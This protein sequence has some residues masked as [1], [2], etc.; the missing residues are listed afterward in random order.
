[1]HLANRSERAYP[2]VAVA[3]WRQRFMTARTFRLAGASASVASLLVATAARAQDT[4][5]L[6]QTLLPDESGIAFVLI[7]RTRLLV[8]RVKKE[9][10]TAHVVEVT[11]AAEPP[12]TFSLRCVDQAAARQVVD[13][14][15]AGGPAMLD[16][17]G[18]CRL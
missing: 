12:F 18:R 2:T 14:L 15:R 7:D 4:I 5:L 17:S 3:F 1:V 9:K 16:V 11:L 6:Q 8:V 13:A 10:G